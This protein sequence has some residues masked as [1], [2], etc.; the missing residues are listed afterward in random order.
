MSLLLISF[1]IFAVL[2]I[3]LSSTKISLRYKILAIAKLLSLPLIAILNMAAYF[4]QGGHEE[5][6]IIYFFLFG[7][8]SINII[9]IVFNRKQTWLHIIIIVLNALFV[10]GLLLL[11]PFI[12]S[13]PVPAILGLLIGC[14]LLG[15]HAYI[16]AYDIRIESTE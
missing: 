6:D 15:L 7:L 10:L 12:I 16:R 1:I 5:M 2:I 14:G 9:N 11:S 3:S 13:E 4:F 8:L